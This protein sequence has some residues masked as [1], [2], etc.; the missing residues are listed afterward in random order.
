MGSPV[1]QTVLKLV[2]KLLSVQTVNNM[3]IQR[4]I[5]LQK[6]LGEVLQKG[7]SVK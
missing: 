7:L 3:N 1:I 5:L 4:I 2:N 6:Q